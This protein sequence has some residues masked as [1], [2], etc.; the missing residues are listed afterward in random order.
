MNQKNNLF[1]FEEIAAVVSFLAIT[2]IA[3]IS[4]AIIGASSFMHSGT[5]VNIMR[6]SYFLKILSIVLGVI[7]FASAIII[8]GTIAS[9]K[10]DGRLAVDFVTGCY[11][12]HSFVKGRRYNGIVSLAQWGDKHLTIKQTEKDIR[13][14]KA[15]VYCSQIL[16]NKQVKYVAEYLNSL[17]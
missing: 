4:I 2:F 16:T 11:T 1:T 6:G 10:I 7:W 14:C 15:D 9:G 5:V 8:A 12:C 13:S 17:K 3:V